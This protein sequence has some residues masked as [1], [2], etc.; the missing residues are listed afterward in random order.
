MITEE[1]NIITPVKRTRPFFFSILCVVVFVYSGFFI[2]FFITAMIFHNW[3][4][5][6]LNDYLPERDITASDILLITITGILLYSLTFFA[7][8]LLWKQKRTGLYIYIISSI[9]ISGIPFL[10]GISNIISV[11]VFAAL[12]VSFIP[13]YRRLN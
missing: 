12:I 1:D 7:A 2:V 3:I 6:V 4:T 8:I 5:R 13:F 10:F 9:L 11:I